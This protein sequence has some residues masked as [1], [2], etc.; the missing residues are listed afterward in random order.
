[1]GEAVQR[2]LAS[3]ERFAQPTPAMF[4]PRANTAVDLFGGA[5][6]A[7]RSLYAS[8]KQLHDFADVVAVL[9]GPKKPETF[10]SAFALADS[11]ELATRYIV[12]A[13]YLVVALPEWIR[14]LLQEMAIIIRLKTIDAFAAVEAKVF[15]IRRQIIDL[16]YVDLRESLRGA[17][18]SA[19]AWRFVANAYFDMYI[20][21]TKQFAQ[22]VI[23]ELLRWL[24][25]MQEFVKAFIGVFEG[26]QTLLTHLMKIDLIPVLIE[27]LG[28]V[29]WVI[30]NLATPPSV[31]LED[32]ADEKGRSAAYARL[33]AWIDKIERRLPNELKL[34]PRVRKAFPLIR[35][36]LDTALL[37]KTQDVSET[38]AFSL[39]PRK[40]PDLYEKFV[41]G[42][43]PFQ[44][45]MNGFVDSLTAN[46]D[47]LFQ[48]SIKVL[49]AV[50]ARLNGAAGQALSGPD[51]EDYQAIQ[52]A[53]AAASQK[54]F[55]KDADALSARL[56]PSSGIALVFE[57]WVARGGI[58]TVG[59]VVPRYVAAMQHYWAEQEARGEE[60][61]VKLT[62]D[63]PTSPHILAQ[64]PRL[65]RTSVPRMKIVAH[66]RALDEALVQAVTDAFAGL[67]QQAHRSGL[68]KLASI[69]AMAG[70]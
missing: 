61:A 45:A 43:Q 37:T 26:L 12:A 10:E 27:I 8:R 50:G 66:G 6:L 19:L 1:V 5:A 30:E 64:R 16:F 56:A 34:I 65:A 69:Q 39:A 21:L 38:G 46:T 48:Q 55:G 14:R 23:D 59:A 68:R 47:K 60:L 17:M 20:D 18:S 9:K 15:E 58:E 28:K 42:L 67:V 62:D 35:S 57:N 29:G 13:L 31:T 33:R 2:I 24:K 40:F 63:L 53:A 51:L 44:T 49:T 54:A 22:I 4:D 52:Q 3:V 70:A 25:G 41:G 36:V 11:L 7:F 32:V